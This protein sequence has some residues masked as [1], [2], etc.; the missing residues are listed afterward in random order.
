MLVEEADAAALVADVMMLLAARGHDVK[1]PDAG[2][3]RRLV[4]LA[5]LMRAEFTAGTTEESEALDSG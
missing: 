3:S 5:A 4:W 2:S 1:V